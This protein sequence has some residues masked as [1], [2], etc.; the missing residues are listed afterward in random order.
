MALTLQQA[1][2]IS[3]DDLQ[4]GILEVFVQESNV[5]DRIPFLTIEGNAYAYNMEAALPGVAFRDV[6]KAY[7]ESTG[8]FA[9]RTE[10]L[11]ILGGDADVDL[12]IAK[13]RSNLND[14]RAAQTR[15][16][17]KALSYRFAW[18]FINGNASQ[19]TGADG[20]PVS[21]PAAWDGLARRLT[22]AQ[23]L[24]SEL[25]A[26]LNYDDSTRNDFFDELEALV[27]QVP[28]INAS[29]GALYA[30]RA[31]IAKIKSAGRRIGGV[32]MLVEDMTGKRVVMWQGIPLLD[33]GEMPVSTVAGA[34]TGQI[35]PDGVIYA[36]R[37]G[38]DESDG[39]VTGLTNGGVQVRDLGEIDEKP[40]LRT[41]IEFYCGMA[42]FSGQAA[43]VLKD[44]PLT[45]APAS[46][47]GS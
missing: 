15:M 20:Q 1:A 19:E 43:A 9:Q 35:I 7:P 23:V 34:P 29:N 32:E 2:Q 42:L 13:T 33:L 46:G 3:T 36:V 25:T 45:G 39:G 31:T 38:Q 30:S 14:Q 37:F 5:L 44:V 11:S 27:A 26:G 17:V 8:T 6:N 16:K 10:A 12:F 40:V 24:T 4:R 21:E 47:T 28:G 41:R 18:Q 22:G